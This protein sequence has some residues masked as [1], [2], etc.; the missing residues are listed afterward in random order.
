MRE[1]DEVAQA[2]AEGDDERSS[3]VVINLPMEPHAGTSS[4]IPSPWSPLLSFE[5]FIE[6][7]VIATLAQGVR[8]SFTSQPLPEPL[9]PPEQGPVV[10]PETTLPKR[11]GK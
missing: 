5:D 8:G 9:P 6:E 1:I 2:S 4:H 7:K 3:P 10:R 11:K